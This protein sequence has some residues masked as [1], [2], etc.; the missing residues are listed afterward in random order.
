VAVG[1]VT[2]GALGVALAAGVGEVDGVVGFVVV[3]TVCDVV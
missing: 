3:V 2:G 1:L